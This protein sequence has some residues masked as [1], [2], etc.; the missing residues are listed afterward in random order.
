LSESTRVSIAWVADNDGDP[1]FGELIDTVS[2]TAVN[3]VK[4]L[5]APTENYAIA[6]NWWVNNFQLPGFEGRWGPF[7]QANFSQF[8]YFPDSSLGFPWSDRAR[9]KLMSNGEKDY[10]QNLAQLDHSS[11]GWLPSPSNGLDIANGAYAPTFLLSVGPFTMLPGDTVHFAFATIIGEQFHGPDS[12]T[13]YP[14][15]SLQPELAYYNF[16]DLVTSAM[17]AQ[18]LYDSMFLGKTDVK[19]DAKKPPLPRSFALYQNYPN[20]FNSST[21]IRFSLVRSCPVKLEVYNLLGER[22]LT[23]IDNHLAA[24]SHRI[25]WD[26]ENSKQDKVASGIYLYRLATDNGSSVKKMVLLK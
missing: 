19:D 13:P 11:G 9:Y 21:E 15:D 24:G 1:V 17:W 25:S 5:R 7:S 23:L 4:I 16:S 14:Y 26:G 20:P 12:I 2:P 6:Y 22:V 3:G 18:F 8:G 10:N